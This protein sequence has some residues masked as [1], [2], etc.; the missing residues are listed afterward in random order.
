MIL[1]VPAGVEVDVLIVK[2]EVPFTEIVAGLNDAVALV[3]RPVALS[4][5]S[6]LNP[7]NEVI[8]TVKLAV[9]PALTVRVE[10][11]T[12]ILKSGANNGFTITL[13]GSEVAPVTPALPDQLALTKYV[14]VEAGVQANRYV[15][16]ELAVT[17]PRELQVTPPFVL[18][19]IVIGAT[20][21]GDKFPKMV[22]L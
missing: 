2:V 22:T 3:G 5:T 20:V 13:T 6:E 8:V 19:S 9:S 15:P 11:F 14:P 7:S 12:T 18:T 16:L 4:K 1:V 21:G 10:G 17:V